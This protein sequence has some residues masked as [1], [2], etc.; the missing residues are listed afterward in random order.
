LSC[1]SSG[2]VCFDQVALQYLYRGQ[3]IVAPDSQISG[4][5]RVGD[6]GGV[7]DAR[8]LLLVMDVRV[9]DL[10]PQFE[11]GDE[12]PQF[13]RGAE[14]VWSRVVTGYRVHGL[15]RGGTARQPGA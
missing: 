7:E 14:I 2:Q 9:E 12:R 8:P 1:R 11:V 10:N 15:L 5:D 3:Q 13:H 6:V 4:K